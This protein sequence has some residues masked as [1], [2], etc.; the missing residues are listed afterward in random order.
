MASRRLQILEWSLF[1]GGLALLVVILAR[2]DLSDLSTRLRQVGWL[3]VAAFGAYML[4]LLTST[5]AWRATIPRES[6]RARLRHLFA[7]FWAGRAVNDLAPLGVV[8]EVLKATVLAHKVEKQALIASVV[9]WNFLNGV[10]VVTWAIA[11]GMLAVSLLRLPSR[12]ETIALAAGM[13]LVV[14]LLLFRLIMRNGL[15]AKLVR[16]YHALPFVRRDGRRAVEKAGEIDARLRSFYADDPRA[17]WRALAWLVLA[18]LTEVLEIWLLMIGLLP[19]DTPGE[20]LVYAL[21][22]HAMSQLVIYATLIV[23]GNIG[24]LEGATALIFRLLGLG[25]LN[26]LALE[27]LRRLRKIL[28]LAIGGTIGMVARAK[29]RRHRHATEA[30]RPSAAPTV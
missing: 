20:L 9:V 15:A 27:L 3:F 16:A 24:V 5:L 28:G 29:E 26:G 23:P 25:A 30:E 12:I 10:V 19:N 6:S 7:A 1:A 17:F 8:G 21:L 18:R 4:T 11:G 14:A 13:A 2:L 22:F